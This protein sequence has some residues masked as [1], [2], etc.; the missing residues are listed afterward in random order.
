MREVGQICGRCGRRAFVQ[1]D[2]WAGRP[3]LTGFDLC[4]KCRHGSRGQKSGIAPLLFFAFVVAG[5]VAGLVQ[6]VA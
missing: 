2:A 3:G 5:V 4:R 6:A 1:V